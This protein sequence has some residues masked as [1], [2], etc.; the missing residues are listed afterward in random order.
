MNCVTNIALSC[1]WV[2]VCHCILKLD[3]IWCL[4]NGKDLHFEFEK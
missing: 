2:H 4:W 1:Y 3:S